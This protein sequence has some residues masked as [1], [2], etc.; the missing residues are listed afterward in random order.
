[1]KTIKARRYMLKLI[2][3][4][5]VLHF[6]QVKDHAGII[7]ILYGIPIGVA[8]GAILGFILEVRSSH[9]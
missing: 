5:I 4:C 8:C 9:R 3:Y 2:T 7:A 1:M 6:T